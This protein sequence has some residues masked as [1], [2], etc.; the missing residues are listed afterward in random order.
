MVS[1]P[2]KKVV[3]DLKKRSKNA[4]NLA[5]K[6]IQEEKMVNPKLTRALKHYL[7]NWEDFTHAGLFS[8]ACEIVGGNSNDVVLSQAS[9]AM[10]AAAFDIHDD[11]IDQ[12]TV[13]MKK[14]TVY[15][16]FGIE[17][18]LLLGN[19]FLIAGF[20]LFVNAAIKFQEEKEKILLNRVKKLLFEIGNAHA[21]EVCVK[22][23]NKITLKNYLKIT[24][25]KAASIEMDMYLGA[26]FGGG[27]ER[28][29]EI[30]AKIGRILGV[31]GTL[32][33]DLI[34]VFDNGEL[35][36]RLVVN[37]LPMPLILAMQDTK[38]NQKIMYFISKKK[39][40]EQDTTKIGSI[41]LT[42]KPVLKIKR[43]M[44]SLIKTG[45]NQAEKLSNINQR[46]KLKLILSNMLEDL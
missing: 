34:D 32:R 4:L 1:Q 13:K 10:M 42:A 43:E 12:S 14:S 6:V 5:K 30:L 7:A 25:M 40:T 28:E 8:I 31:I 45:L 16:K 21:I 3:A 11:I 17:I 24:R 44:K 20:K 26:I 15:G 46:S 22:K 23:N 36:T 41:T 38:I 9:I 2:G 27:N 29:V 35:L 18:A 37:D 39:L 33:D 19:A